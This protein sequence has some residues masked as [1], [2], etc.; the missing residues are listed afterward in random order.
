MA[1]YSGAAMMSRKGSMVLTD[2]D[3]FPPGTVVHERH[4][5]LR[6]RRN[7]GRVL[8][9]QPDDGLRLRAAPGVRRPCAAARAATPIRWRTSAFYQEGGIAGT[10]RGE[11]VLVG[12]ADFMAQ[13]GV[14]L[15][16][17]IKLKTGVFLAVDKELVAVFAVKYMAS[18]NVDAALQAI[19]TTASARCSP[20]GTSISPRR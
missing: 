17:E 4:E 7:P 8:C 20:C 19:C 14:R 5:G 1:S 18:D 16:R 11:S 15:P 3:L 13:M 9:Q 10:I 6:P 2:S 12:R